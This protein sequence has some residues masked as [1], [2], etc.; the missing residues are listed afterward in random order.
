MHE[1]WE[2]MREWGGG[3]PSACSDVQLTEGS[4]PGY[5]FQ[6]RIS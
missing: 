5:L 2:W 4:G 3:V 1:D 6:V